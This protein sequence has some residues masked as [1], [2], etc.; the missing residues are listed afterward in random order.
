MKFSP[1]MILAHPAGFF[2]CFLLYFLI[3]LWHSYYSQPV[4]FEDFLH[5]LWH[6]YYSQPVKFED[7]WHV[8]CQKYEFSGAILHDFGTKSFFAKCVHF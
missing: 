7:F 1:E 2:H 3:L 8:L 5:V 6:S 4:K